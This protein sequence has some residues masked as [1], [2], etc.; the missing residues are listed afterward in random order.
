MSNTGRPGRVTIADVAKAAGVSLST[1]DRVLNGRAPVRMDTAKHIHEVAAS[2]GFHLTGVIK[3]R[4]Q[5]KKV[6]FKLGFL[7]EQPDSAFYSD[8]GAALSR[9]TSAFK[10]DCE[11]AQVEFMQDISP[12]AV[13]HRLRA[14]GERVDAIA[15]VA[16]DHSLISSEIERLKERGVPVFAL[17]SDLSTPSRAGYAGLD[18]RRV[19]RTAAWFITSLAR[20]PGKLAIFV[21]SHR[22]QCQELAE[23]SFRSYVRE[24]APDFELMEPLVTLESN[25]LAEE[26][27]RELLHRHPDI[28]GVFVA[29][30]G[31][32]GV[33]NALRED[34]MSNLGQRPIGIARE[35]TVRVRQGLISKDLHA[36]LSHPLPQLA[37]DLVT[38]MVQVLAN[39]SQGLQQAI[40][41]LDIQTPEST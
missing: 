7:L 34:R 15:I 11:S 27:A 25:E 21:G 9:A 19:G 29:G 28:V 6:K 31:S 18:N 10:E 16:A 2:M 37:Q 35:L 39:E 23:M 4:V 14:L 41:P 20:E 32:E 22:F 36:A 26:G 8:L 40:V 3:E 5:G 13:S 24:N 38:M 12:E 30:G 1:V 17:I 33:L